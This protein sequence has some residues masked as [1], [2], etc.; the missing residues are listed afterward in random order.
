M[1]ECRLSGSLHLSSPDL[2][3]FRRVA[4]ACGQVRLS[5][6][7]YRCSSVSLCSILVRLIH[8][9]LYPGSSRP[10]LLLLSVPGRWCLL[11]ITFPNIIKPGPRSLMYSPITYC[12]GSRATSVLNRYSFLRYCATNP[13]GVHCAGFDSFVHQFFS[14]ARPYIHIS[15]HHGEPIFF[16]KRY[17]CMGAFLSFSLVP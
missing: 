9:S 13:A 2:S 4:R 11:L 17:L 6:H 1:N 3:F 10:A 16:I 5:L 7:Q 14:T 12:S 8:H 15:L